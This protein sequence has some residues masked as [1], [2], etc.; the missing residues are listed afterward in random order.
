M[1][2]NAGR[3]V[4]RYRA[5]VVL[6]VWMLLALTGVGNGWYLYD[7]RGHALC[8]GCAFSLAALSGLFL[9][10]PLGVVVAAILALVLSSKEGESLMAS[11]VVGG[12]PYLIAVGFYVLGL[13]IGLAMTLNAGEVPAF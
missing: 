4:I 3:I 1:Q 12:R 6:S 9:L 7:P 2:E 10:G 13:M 11:A 5:F 8:L